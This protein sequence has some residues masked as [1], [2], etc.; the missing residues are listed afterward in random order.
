MI[1]I[2]GSF[3][4][5]GGQLLR[6]S[7]TLSMM[8]GQKLRIDKIR[9]NRKNPGLRPQHLKAVQAA[10]K[11]SGGEVD[12]ASINS[13]KI[14][15]SPGK[16]QAGNYNFDIGTAGS[17]ILV[18][19]T[20]L[21]PL[22]SVSKPSTVMISGG[23]HVPWSPCYHYL[24]L[25]YLPFMWKI[26]FDIDIR[27]EKAGFYPSGGG[28]IR[29]RIKPTKQ[30]TALSLI[31]RGRLQEI[32]GISAVANLPRNI[33]TRQRRQVIGRMGRHYPLNDIRVTEFPAASP[34]CL[35]LCLATP[36]AS[37]LD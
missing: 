20:I 31:E 27:M 9:A 37:F 5:G 4:E 32:R 36:S 10:T 2:D 13:Q 30:H 33:A 16:I 18:L 14:V 25:N 8:T 11:I 1:D 22:S 34:G 7:L 29:A 35:D 17:A 12:G 6:S 19:Q 21:L 23:T 28:R 15:F 3:G 24:D 26:G